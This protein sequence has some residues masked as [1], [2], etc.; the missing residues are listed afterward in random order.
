MSVAEDTGFDSLSIR[1]SY[2]WGYVGGSITRLAVKGYIAQGGVAMWQAITE[3]DG[4]TIVAWRDDPTY[5]NR[6]RT[7]QAADPCNAVWWQ[8]G[9]HDA[10]LVGVNNNQLQNMALSVLALIDASFTTVKPVYVSGTAG[11]AP[12]VICDTISQVTTDRMAALALKLS[13]ISHCQKGLDMPLIRAIDLNAGPGCHQNPESGQVSHG[14]A[15]KGW[16][17]R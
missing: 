5:I 14:L 2:R 7:E 15:L 17:G 9:M 12:D 10:D 11:Y 6:F 4:G 1:S 3:Y 13:Q 8:L 16:I